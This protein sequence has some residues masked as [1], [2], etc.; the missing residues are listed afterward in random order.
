LSKL[1]LIPTCFLKDDFNTNTMA[2]IRQPYV[3]VKEVVIDTPSI[4]DVTNDLT[5]GGVIVAPVGPKL[6]LVSGPDDFLSKYTVDG[7][8]IPRNADITLVNAY[9]LSYSGPLVLQ[10]SVNT[11]AIGGLLFSKGEASPVKVY[12]KD[13][14][15]M[16]KSSSVQ[17]TITPDAEAG[18]QNTA[19][20]F[21][22]G[23]TVFYHINCDR[24]ATYA[25]F[26][27]FYE[28]NTLEDISAG[29][30]KLGNIHVNA[31]THPES[32]EN[33]LNLVLY[34][35]DA[36]DKDD[37]L[38]VDQSL[39]VNASV[40][41]GDPVSLISVPDDK[42]L[43]ALY[44]EIALG[45]NDH[46]AYIPTVFG[47]GRFVLNID[48]NEYQCSL[49]PDAVDE[50]G[51]GIY[52]DYINTQGIGYSVDIYANDITAVPTAGNVAVEFGNS[53]LNLD[54]CA[55][56]ENMMSAWAELAD[57]EYY[58]I[59]GLSTFGATAIPVVMRA[60][61]AAESMK[62]MCPIDA[63]RNATT[64]V[65]V[66]KYFNDLV[67]E[68]SAVPK[69]I[70]LGPF[71]KNISLLGWTTYIAASTLYWQRV[72][73]NKA[74]SAEFAGVFSF[75]NGRMN[76][77]NPVKIFG[78]AER[79]ALLNLGKPVNWAAYN[80]ERNVY[81]MNDNRTLQGDST[82]IVAE[83]CISRQVLKISRDVD[84]IMEQFTS[85]HNTTETQYRVEDA[86]NYYF[87][88]NIMNQRYKPDD[89]KVICADDTLNN[90]A[91]K[92]SNGLKVIVK[93]RYNRSIKYIEVVN[94][95]YPIGVDFSTTI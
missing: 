92:N 74:N 65:G 78:K 34:H 5:I 68:Y 42:W 31:H 21:A 36:E 15:M 90:D 95:V 32:A 25:D 70:A 77:T 55:A 13:E 43:F 81:F 94:Q 33:K 54:E 17:I 35:T 67:V 73:A 1:G 9:F 11:N 86:V 60:Q 85:E 49:Q 58:R 28:C 3:E 24:K 22:F 48:D 66:R 45:T 71:D 50:N 62:C 76:Y 91:V 64:L 37:A 82:K 63:P 7:V 19:W 69:G 75:Q 79:E 61:K 8:S 88:W 38:K 16:T 46:K 89:F 72:F 84:R 47:D 6:A 12:K 59:A 39:M 40:S 52:V 14:Q 41:V 27:S 51:S 53:G 20:S 2:K 26:V 23:D 30:E 18:L 29:M 10:R 56:N 4:G 80:Y 87:Q 83:E 57:Q 44:G 93:V